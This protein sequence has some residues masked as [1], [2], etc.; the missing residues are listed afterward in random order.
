MVI[1]FLLVFNLI[2]YVNIDVSE[3]YEVQLDGIGTD[4]SL[5]EI[6]LRMAKIKRQRIFLCGFSV[7]LLCGAIYM[8]KETSK[9]TNE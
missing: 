4:V 9:E 3:K 8:V 2:A 6:D 5:A 7:L 1:F